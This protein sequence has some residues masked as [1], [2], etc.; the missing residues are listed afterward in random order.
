MILLACLFF[1][2][3]VESDPI[4]EAAHERVHED[5]SIKVGSVDGKIGHGMVRRP[6]SAATEAYDPYRSGLTPAPRPFD[7][8]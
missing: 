3:P 4:K 6:S 8:S 5:N 1:M 2:Q 7:R